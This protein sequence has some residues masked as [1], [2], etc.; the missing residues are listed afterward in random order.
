MFT[1]KYNRLLL[2]FCL[3][4]L[5]WYVSADQQQISIESVCDSKPPYFGYDFTQEELD[6]L[7]AQLLPLHREWLKESKDLE[8]Q[9]ELVNYQDHRRIN[10]CG[11]NLQG[12]HLARK[13]LSMA[14][15]MYAE[16]Q[17]ADLTASNLSR[18]WLD[19]A[20]LKEAKLIKT[21]LTKAYLYNVVL[22]NANLIRADL[23]ETEASNADF[24]GAELVEA[25]LT[26]AILHEANLT[27]ANL[28]YAI[29]SNSDFSNVNLSQSTFYPKV[30]SYPDPLSLVP[31]FH[32]REKLFKDVQ[33]YDT[34]AGSP[35]LASLRAAYRKTGMRETER[36]ITNLLQLQIQERNWNK[37]GW[38]QIGSGLSYVLFNLTTAYG[39]YPQRPLSLLLNSILFFAFIYWVALRF[40]SK[41]NYFEVV[42][43]SN[44]LTSSGRRGIKKGGHGLDAYH[45]LR[46][47]R[48]CGDSWIKQLLLE[49]K[50]L[51]ISIYF[52]VLSAFHIGWKQYNVGVWIK[53]LQP[54]E[55]SLRVRK[56][57]MRSIS[58][59]Q[60]LLSLYLMVIWILTQ[61]GR[62][63]D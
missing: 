10:L 55:F 3:L 15:L 42:W 37:G 23:T 35:V 40:D 39:L 14:N 11:A 51:R 21:N 59:F 25:N 45:S 13:N 1:R 54:R 56:G 9:G 60:S 30:N 50:M 34:H 31:T 53:Q 41:R 63:F 8:K 19:G 4:L 49:F 27:G 47:K 6:S 17:H 52:S 2:S 16:L 29:L 28:F 32:H 20:S 48:C 7:L 38:E 62:P 43:E 26:K 24:T 36:I 44:V 33:Y 22:E 12:L 57:W 46:F 58:G 18:A 61:F 5:P